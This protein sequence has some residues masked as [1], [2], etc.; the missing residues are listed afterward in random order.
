MKLRRLSFLPSFVV[1]AL[2]ATA[3]EQATATSWYWD[4][5]GATTTATGGTGSWTQAG[6]LWRNASATGT[7]TAY[8]DAAGP[9]ID[10][11]ANLVLAGGT[12]SVTMTASASTSY[13]LNK[14]TASNT[15]TLATNTATATFVGTTPTVDVASGKSLVWGMDLS[16][17]SATVA[18]TSAGTW[19]FN[20]R[21][22]QEQVVSIPPRSTC[23]PGRSSSTP[24]PPRRTSSPAPA[25]S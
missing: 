14:I 21:G 16:A 18:K 24:P 6:V 4:A 11:A 20:N 10:T 5:D 3:L 23:R 13:N 12:D 2:A 8:N 19:Q 15:Y 1:L 22:G 9:Q 7:L 17:A 25:G